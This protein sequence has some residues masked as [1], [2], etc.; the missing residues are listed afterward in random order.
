MFPAVPEIEVADHADALRIRR[1]DRKP[2]ARQPVALQPVRPQLAIDVMVIAFA[3]QVEI[4]V[5]QL[6]SKIVRIVL[7]GHGAIR[8]ADPQQVGSQW[9][10]PCQNAFEK[11]AGMQAYQ[12]PGSREIFIFPV[13]R[14]TFRIWLEY[15][16]DTDRRFSG[17]PGPTRQ[18]VI[19]EQ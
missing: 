15:P 19:A 17:M 1:P 6:W 8:I 13:H 3:E 10:T 14:D 4:V 11:A 7:R 12:W 5:G 18:F 16:D 2:R 9:P